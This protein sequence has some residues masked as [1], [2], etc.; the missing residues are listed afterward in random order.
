[1]A[2]RKTRNHL[3]AADDLLFVVL[4]RL[5]CLQAGAGAGASEMASGASVSVRFCFDLAVQV[6]FGVSEAF[7]SHR[8]VTRKICVMWR[9]YVAWKGFAFATCVGLRLA[10]GCMWFRRACGAELC[11]T[12]C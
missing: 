6:G 8:Y 3:I 2:I 4:R 10:S 9:M 5:F 11:K 7:A 1:M 12:T